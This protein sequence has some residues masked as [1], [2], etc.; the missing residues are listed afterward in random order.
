MRQIFPRVLIYFRLSESSIS[1]RW[2]L[3]V[4][5]VLAL[6]PIFGSAI[7]VVILGGSIIA[8]AYFCLNRQEYLPLSSTEKAIA[9]IFLSYF[10]IPLLFALLHENRIPGL[11]QISN[12]LSFLLVL[13]LMPV[14]RV[15]YRPYW[16]AWISVA[17]A[18][19]GL[20]AGVLSALEV[21]ARG[22]GR[23]ELLVGNP[24]ILAYLAGVL[25]LFNGCLA[26]NGH[27][28]RFLLY[29]AG[30]TGSLVA[31]VLSGSRAPLVA[32][33]CI[34]LAASSVWIVKRCRHR[35][36]DAATAVSIVALTG[37]AGFALADA[38]MV[39]KTLSER[40]WLPFDLGADQTTFAGK[41][42]SVSLR[43][44]MLEAGVA[45]FLKQPLAGVGR[46]NVMNVAGAEFED[47]SAFPFSHL[48][49]AFLTEGVGSGVL[50]LVVLFAVLTTPL[51][52]VGKLVSPWCDMARCQVAFTVLFFLTNIG[53][54]HDIMT[55]H[56]STLV[57]FFSVLGGRA[58][59][60]GR[61]SAGDW[62]PI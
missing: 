10:S 33:G 14:L 51:L 37:I 22:G 13:P 17:I 29:A 42:V 3:F 50:G 16:I 4:S 9:T 62:R 32:V 1:F 26:I 61:K 15:H 46:Q 36:R 52:A 20:L 45:V 58:A 5:A 41:D 35:W 43:I 53:F 59:N 28:A 56:F 27:G 11:R 19:G 49:N 44:E 24:L 48:H 7:S 47:D 55:L 30:A 8:S 25:F 2:I 6:M 39:P 54:Y 60:D 21:F 57:C 23:A 34:C 18:M 12:N 40:V 31:L 38:R